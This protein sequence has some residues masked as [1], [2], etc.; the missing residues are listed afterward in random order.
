MQ[1]ASIISSKNKKNKI[2]ILFLT[3]YEFC[4]VNDT[5]VDESFVFVYFVIKTRIPFSLTEFKQ[6]VD[7]NT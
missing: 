3:T 2:M 1:I 7:T 6:S 5:D 4:C